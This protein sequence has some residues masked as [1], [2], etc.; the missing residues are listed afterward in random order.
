MVNLRRSVGWTTPAVD[1]LPWLWQMVGHG[2]PGSGLTRFRY[3]LDCS[4]GCRASHSLPIAYRLMS[5]S[6]STSPLPPYEP[7][8]MIVG[9]GTSAA[10]HLGS[11]ASLPTMQ[12]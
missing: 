6:A 4:P 10:P 2:R 3:F 9:F 11:N 7:D 1:G 12:R 8:A 5:A